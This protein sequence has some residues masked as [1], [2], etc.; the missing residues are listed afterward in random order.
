MT[1]AP[2]T[3]IH[4]LAAGRA[5]S[6]TGWEAGWIG[7]MVA[8]YAR[9]HSTVWMSA[10]LFLTIATAG[11][12][13]PIA[14]ALGDRYDRRRVMIAS[15]LTTAVF[16]LGMV[17]AHAPLLLIALAACA[18]LAQAPFMPASSASV[19]NLVSDDRLEWANSTIS[20]GRNIGAL[21]GPL[22]GGVLSAA[23]GSSG[24]FAIAA[25]GAL[26][27]AAMVWSV[28]GNFGGRAAHAHHEQHGELRAGFVFVWHS[29]VLRGMTTAWMVLLF[30][31]GPI[32]VAELPLAHEFGQG[33][34][35][36]G[37]IAAC[38]GGGAIAGSFLGRVAASV[39]RSTVHHHSPKGV[40]CAREI[41]PLPVTPS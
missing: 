20:V 23:I 37:I 32:L 38:W 5:I 31:L 8:V 2:T 26:L 18:S 3:A 35:G 9:T 33:A 12:V 21:L 19:P 25:A 14:G 34:A 10:A 28:S 7:L 1:T 40:R 30:L 39:S 41:I 6:V 22:I 11:L 15:E 24:V 4:R 17:F 29:P 16:A 13:A 36:Y 27:A